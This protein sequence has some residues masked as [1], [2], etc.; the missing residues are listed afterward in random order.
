MQSESVS[1]LGI[2]RTTF[3]VPVIGLVQFITCGCRGITAGVMAIKCGSTAIIECANWRSAPQRRVTLRA[4]SC[5]LFRT[6]EVQIAFTPKAIGL[7]LRRR[8]SLWSNSGVWNWAV[9][10]LA[11][12]R[13]RWNCCVRL[14]ALV[15]AIDACIENAGL[16]FFSDFTFLMSRGRF[17]RELFIRNFDYFLLAAPRQSRGC[18][19]ASASIAIRIRVWILS[20][21]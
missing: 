20:R 12:R 13:L 6:R 19:P 4:S 16:E 11:R 18:I 3:T 7:V 5:R 9:S 8:R 17:S 10:R 14:R 15:D 1:T 21:R 2:S